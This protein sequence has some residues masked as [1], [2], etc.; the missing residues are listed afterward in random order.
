M[1]TCARCGLAYEDVVRFCPL[2]GEPLGAEHDPYLGKILLG[3]FE[4]LERIGAGAMGTV[5]RAWQNTMDRPV[6]VK[7]LKRDLLRDPAVVKRFYRE[8]RAVARLSHPNIITVF[9]VGESDDGAPYI[10]ME[11]V[12]GVSLSALLDAEGRLELGRTIRIA[13]QIASALAEAHAAQV[14]HRDLKPENIL[15]APR[16]RQPDLVKVLDFG[17][18]K[19][20]VAPGESHLTSSGALFGTPHYLAPEQAAG[21]D[22]DHRADL[23]SLG[24]ILYRML[25]GRLPFDGGSGM[26]VVLAQLYEQPPEPRALAPDIPPEVEQVVLRAMAKDPAARYQSAEELQLALAAL[27][28]PAEPRRTVRGLITPSQARLPSQVGSAVRAPLARTSTRMRRMARRPAFWAPLLAL[29]LGAGAVAWLQLGVGGKTRAASKPLPA[30][31]A[32]AIPIPP[33]PP[34]PAAQAPH[35]LRLA[36]EGY[37]FE[38]AP[39]SDARA[40]VPLTFVIDADDPE[41]Q[42]LRGARV[43]LGMRGPDKGQPEQTVAAHER[44]PGRYVAVGTLRQSGAHHVHVYAMTKR[45]ERL[46]VWFD[47]NVLAGPVAALAPVAGHHEHGKLERKPEPGAPAPAEPAK[48]E[49]AESKPEPAPAT[50]E[51]P[52][53]KPAESEPPPVSREP[54]PVS[55]QPIAQPKSPPPPAPQQQP[56]SP[57]TPRVVPP[58]PLGPPRYLPRPWRYRPYVPPRY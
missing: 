54:A 57:K 18:A 53:S 21:S 36:E 30:P 26:Q 22:V 10:V 44:A 3:Q 11:M 31:A 43:E 5:Y 25:T 1:T 47:L 41:G 46:K 28:A 14:V 56:Q 32:L 45:G 29:V 27:D 7:V 37:A 51:E 9:L 33:P 16:R 2:D 23:Y 8:A 17:I 4:L 39:P 52:E 49:A 42:P 50:A 34:P 20:L 55:E 24:V 40:G 19:V 15:C 6:A 38:V 12:E 35:A 13:T 58:P 48:S